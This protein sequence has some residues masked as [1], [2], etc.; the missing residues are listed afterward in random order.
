[1]RRPVD[2]G[3]RLVFQTVTVTKMVYRGIFA[4]LAV[5]AV[6]SNPVSAA[7]K[8][9]DFA[10]R[11]VGRISCA[12]LLDALDKK[13]KQRLTLF[14]TWLEGYISATNQLSDNTFDITPWQTTELLLA[15]L[16]RACAQDSEKNFMA[17][18]GRLIAEMR[19]LSLVEQSQVVKLQTAST[20]Q[21][22]YREIVERV[23]RRLTDLGYEFTTSSVLGEKSLIELREQVLA[24]QKA[25]K[26]PPTGDLDQHTLLNL[27]VVPE[28][29]E[30]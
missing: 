4:A 5:S 11:G 7:D 19:P 22:Q 21:V 2:S 6:L 12:E 10:I 8:D 27:F 25:S 18:V 20:V 16:G 13:D 24:Y 28:K 29:A 26:L 14:G 3:R 15:L 1:M 23:R 30:E 17:V 9:G